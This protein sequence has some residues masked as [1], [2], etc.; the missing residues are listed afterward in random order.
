MG[1]VD[2][3]HQF[4]AQARRADHRARGHFVE[5]RVLGRH[6]GIARIFAFRHGHEFEVFGEFHRNVLER[7]HR[8]VGAAFAHGHFEFLHEESLAAHLRE[9]A[10]ED[11]VAR[12]VMPSRSTSASG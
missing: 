5:A 4:A 12:V 3:N 2:A 1:I 6:E 11:L 10:V 8:E 7:M 9:R